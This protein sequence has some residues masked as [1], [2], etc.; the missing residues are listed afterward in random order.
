MLGGDSPVTNPR[1][2][3]APAVDVI[4][5]LPILG[6]LATLGHIKH[7]RVLVALESRECFLVLLGF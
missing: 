5:I 1:L 4:L 3:A 2:I 7:E 6:A